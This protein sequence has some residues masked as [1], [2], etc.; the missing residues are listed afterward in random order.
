MEQMKPFTG[1]ELRSLVTSGSPAPRAPE[2]APLP[3]PGVAPGPMSGQ[4]L[5][6]IVGKSSE[7]RR[8]AVGA[9]EDVARSGL[10]GLGRGTIGLV[11]LPGDIESLGRAGL[12]YAGANVGAEPALPTS[13][14]MISKAQ[15][16]SPLVKEVLDYKPEYGPGRYAK[17]IGEF[18]PS[19]VGGP[20]SVGARL[21]GTVGA[22]VATQAAE[23][24]L[25][26]S[27]MEGTGY[28]TA[29]K[30]AASIPGYAAGTKI[31]GA[32]R[33]PFAG[34]LT[35]GREAEKRIAGELG[36]DISAKGKYG[37]KATPEEIAETAGAVPVAGIAGK[38]T[39]GLI[40][41]S[42]DRVPETTQG[43]FAAAAQE[44]RNQGPGA[45]AKQI[46]DLFGGAPVNPFDEIA[47]LSRRAAAVNT[48][49]YKNLYALPHAQAVTSPELVQVVQQLPRG[50]LNDVGEL[51]RQQGV[52]PKSLGMV[53]GRGGSWTINPSQPM[54]IQFW[55]TVKRQL[56]V[57]AQGIKE[58]LSGKIKDPSLYTATTGTV[59]KLKTALKPLVPEYGV[60]R[61]EAAEILG[62]KNAVDLGTKFLNLKPV[63]VDQVYRNVLNNPSVSDDIKREF[64]YGVAGEY[65]RQLMD[66]PEKALQMFTGKDAPKKMRLFSDALAPISPEAGQQIMGQVL[67]QNLNNS[68]QALKPGGM[69]RVGQLIPYAGTGAAASI[70]QLGEILAQ[71]LVWAQ[72]P[73]ALALAVTSFAGGKYF[74]WKEGRI[75]ARVL[76]LSMD[77]SKTKE[78]VA[79]AAQDPN[80]RSFIQKL[81]DIGQR[82]GRLSAGAT[83][84]TEPVEE[85]QGRATGGRVDPQIHAQ[86]LILAA[87]R[88]RKEASG[89]TESLL[90]QPDEH[91][92][93][94]LD[95]AKR[96]I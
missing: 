61:G 62:A 75:A 60:V 47:E 53:V 48:P 44:L 37:I 38:R 91:I 72:T 83:I 96:H 90:E 23:D 2:P 95:I 8:P 59:E 45:V 46:D 69:S 51:L 80:A 86:R 78:L 29:A 63:E 65:R 73:G 36:K 21:A 17:T 89:Q 49:A 13:Q 58:P 18:L 11:G 84:G 57:A 68:V 67:A 25:K 82:Y 41:R 77:P 1:E 26:G 42:A 94:A 66:A 28:E 24:V 16:L 35:P 6:E 52:D 74:N 54:P 81:S 15:R 19:M 56:D 92:V 93:K 64:A 30:I 87:E 9:G 71:P 22:G 70:V 20:G 3:S 10:A 34:T 31:A 76:Q 50:M 43:E 79:L 88:A 32:A 12:R 85:R 40:Q 14:E 33:A 27:S 7:T 5:R 4:Q 39:Q 55:D